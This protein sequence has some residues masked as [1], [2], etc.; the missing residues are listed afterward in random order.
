[1][2]VVHALT[3]L[4]AKFKAFITVIDFHSRINDGLT[5]EWY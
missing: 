1:M 2:I 4:I 5:F 3:S